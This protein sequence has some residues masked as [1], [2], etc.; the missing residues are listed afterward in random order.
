MSPGSG[1]KSGMRGLRSGQGDG[2][3]SRLVREIGGDPSREGCVEG[4]TALVGPV[5][6]PYQARVGGGEAGC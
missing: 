6:G 5:G 2:S 4:E 3:G 1:V